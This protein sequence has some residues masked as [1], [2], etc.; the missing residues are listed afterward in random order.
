MRSQGGAADLAQAV[1]HVQLDW[2][3]LL[4]FP[5]LTLWPL[6]Q[7]WALLVGASAVLVLVP[8]L[9]PRWRRG[10]ARSFQMSVHGA[11]TPVAVRAGETL[12][13]AGLR[14]GLALPYECRNGGCGKC[15]CTVLHGEV[16][17]GVYQRS[18]L[19]DAQR[20]SGQALM[21]CAT[22]L[23]DLEIEVE[24]APPAQPAARR[25]TA[26]GWRAWSA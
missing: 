2:F 5:L 14:E 17:H 26:R 25:A 8:W 1:T 13:E 16:D 20:A 24:G 3:Y 19:S 10:A 22:P 23:A 12:L 7:V 9:P 11:A 6:G 18:A 21:C 15:R 4:V